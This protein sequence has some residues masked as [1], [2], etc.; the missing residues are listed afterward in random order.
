MKENGEL[1]QNW[2]GILGDRS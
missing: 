2:Q 1:K